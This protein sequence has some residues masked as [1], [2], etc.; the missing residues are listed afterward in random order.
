MKRIEDLE[1]NKLENLVEKA[2]WSINE[3]FERA[4]WEIGKTWL[5]DPD[6]IPNK[7]RSVAILWKNLDAQ[8]LAKPFAE[9]FPKRSIKV[10]TERINGKHVIKNLETVKRELLNIQP[11]PEVVLILDVVSGSGGTALTIKETVEDT[12]DKSPI[13]YFYCVFGSIGLGEKM[14]KN[15]N[16]TSIVASIYPA[17]KKDF[18]SL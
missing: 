12:L 15:F 3:P 16:Y 7:G 10:S 2:Y 6:F 13:F 14:R 8:A 9:A 4:L 18:R 11:P 1:K 17:D 5:N